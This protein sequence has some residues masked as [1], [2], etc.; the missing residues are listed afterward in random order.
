MICAHVRQGEMSP[1]RSNPT[2]ARPGC[3][4]THLPPRSMAGFSNSG[5]STPHARH[6]YIAVSGMIWFVGSRSHTIR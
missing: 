5:I 4:A 6:K 1:F 3:D 2:N